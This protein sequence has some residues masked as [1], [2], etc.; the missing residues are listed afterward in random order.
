M[1]K[2][3]FEESVDIQSRKIPS[4]KL[5]VQGQTFP[6]RRYGQSIDG[7]NTILFVKVVEKGS[8]PF[9]GPSPSNVRNEQKA[10]FIKKDQ[11]GPTSVGVFLYEANGTVSNERSLPRLFVKHVAPASDSSTPS[12]RGVSIRDWDDSERRTVGGSPLP[13]GLKSI[14]RSDT[15]QPEGRSGGPGQDAFFELRSAWEG[16]LGS[17]GALT[18]QPP[19]LD[20]SEAIEIPNSLKH[21]KPVLWLAGSCPLWTNEWPACAAFPVALGFHGVSYPLLYSS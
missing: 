7:R 15:P 12:L 11:M 21:S 1:A 13:R 4:S 16:G 9:R 18:L 8:L 20:R 2:Q 19:F 3:M 17:V 5:K 6:F 10:R 14:Y